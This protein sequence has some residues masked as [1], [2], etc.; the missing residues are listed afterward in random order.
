M[1]NAPACGLIKT[2]NPVRTAAPLKE[3]AD[4]TRAAD[5]ITALY[6]RL[7]Q[8]DANGGGSYSISNQKSMHRNDRQKTLS[9]YFIL[10][11]RDRLCGGPFSRWHPPPV[12]ETCQIQHRT[13]VRFLLD[14]NIR[15]S[16][17]ANRTK[18]RIRRVFS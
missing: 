4:T 6:C 2:S 18:V 16:Y 10:S 9:I 14:R 13:F 12:C 11:C 15:S 8:E 5:K 1:T 7:S 3:D 17:N